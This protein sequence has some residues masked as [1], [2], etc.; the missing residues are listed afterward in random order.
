MGRGIR[1][2]DEGMEREGLEELIGERAGFSHNPSPVVSGRARND[3]ESR[4]TKRAG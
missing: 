1:A 4:S 2:G 3:L